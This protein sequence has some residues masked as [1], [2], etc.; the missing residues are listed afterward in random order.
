MAGVNARSLLQI[1]YDVATKIVTFFIA[2]NLV[3]TEDM[4]LKF[5][6]ALLPMFQVNAEATV[7]TN[8]FFDSLYIKST[9]I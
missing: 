2:G 7:S 6:G 3:H 4:T 1:K 9:R 8:S 5:G